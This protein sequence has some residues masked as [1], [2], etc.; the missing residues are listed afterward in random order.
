MFHKTRNGLDD[1]EDHNLHI[2]PLHQINS[3][4]EGIRRFFT[5]I[6]RIKYFFDLG[7]DGPSPFLFRGTRMKIPK[8]MA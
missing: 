2:S 1:A 6:C 5:E 7:K 4:R 3:V 8:Q